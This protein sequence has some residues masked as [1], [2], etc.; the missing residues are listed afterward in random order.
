MP[1]ILQSH[2]PAGTMGLD[3]RE[4][5]DRNRPKKRVRFGKTPL[6]VFDILNIKSL[7]D[8]I[9]RSY[10]YNSD[11]MRM[12]QHALSHREKRRLS[13]GCSSA[14]LCLRGLEAQINLRKGRHLRKKKPEF[15]IQAVLDEQ[16][17]HLKRFER[18][19][20][21]AIRRVSLAKSMSSKVDAY[22]MA[23]LD[24][25]YVRRHVCNSVPCCAITMTQERHDGAE[26]ILQSVQP[27][28]DYVKLCTCCASSPSPRRTAG[29]KRGKK[30]ATMVS[31]KASTKRFKIF[32]AKRY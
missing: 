4:Q 26:K 16:Q 22:E 3:N 13:R 21:D 29:P 7:S 18:C 23:L 1:R 9:R 25:L 14:G 32:N 8:E 17:K 19:D 12:M 30:V 11:E 15:A 27:K 24:E 31:G 6:V 10:W 2:R 20:P 28:H 5:V